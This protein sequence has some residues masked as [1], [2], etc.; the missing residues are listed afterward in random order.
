MSECEK[1][2]NIAF[3]EL[4]NCYF[5][6]YAEFADEAGELIHGIKDDIS[7]SEYHALLAFEEMLKGY[8]ESIYQIRLKAKSHREGVQT[9]N[10]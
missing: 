10:N 1:E 8:H 3:G 6:V 2:I 5:R 7:D 4:E 9:T